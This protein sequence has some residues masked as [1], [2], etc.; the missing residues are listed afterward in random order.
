MTAPVSDDDT[1]PSATP[2]GK[3][4][5]PRSPDAAARLARFDKANQLPLVLS[6]VLPVLLGVGDDQSAATR[7]IFLL[8]WID[9]VVDLVMHS[10]FTVHYLKTGR[11]KFDLAVVIL[12]S[13]F[14]FIIPGISNTRFI[15]VVR[16][17]RI[18]RL[19]FASGAAKAL[20][21]RLGR[22]AIVAVVMVF[23][24]AYIAYDA[25]HLT[26]PEFATYSDS[27]W[28]G[29]VTLTTVGYGDIVPKTAIGRWAGV[30]LMITGVGIIG[31]LA[32]SLASFLRL[33]KS[34]PT[35]SSPTEAAP[36]PHQLVAPAVVTAD[37]AVTVMSL[38]A[39]LAQLDAQLAA[40]QATASGESGG[41]AS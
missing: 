5:E 24:C 15:V 13:P 7:I 33:D 20:F 28:W 9:F 16:F 14:F 41:G 19:L 11:G 26:N 17:A 22:A 21:E 38:R 30:I 36:G 6:A 23:V 1:Q 10:R 12:T 27:L 40:V 39:Q 2:R 29:I 25:E 4:G 8:S 31:A 18:L 3:P 32:G 37:V 35:G 34:K